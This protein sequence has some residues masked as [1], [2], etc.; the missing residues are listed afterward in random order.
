MGMLA[1]QT[2]QFRGRLG[3]GA[4]NITPVID[5]IFLLI[6][7]FLV[8][9]RFVEAEN[10]AVVVP[11]GCKSAWDGSGREEGITLT[12]INEADG[13]VFAVGADRIRAS[14]DEEMQVLAG[15]LASLI[16]GWRL[17]MRAEWS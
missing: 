7:F 16:G 13:V 8:L 12:V 5:I 15:R 2:E 3:P 11:D 4:F 9:C 1:G 14:E 10:P 17:W 6:I